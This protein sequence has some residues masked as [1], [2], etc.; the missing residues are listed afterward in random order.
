MA[1]LCA[2][3]MG[4][5]SLWLL[6]QILSKEQFG[7]YAFA[8]ATVSM[9]IPIGTVGLD[10]AALYRHSR[11]E[12]AAGRFAGGQ[13]VGWVVRR[14][15]ILGITISLTLA[16]GALALPDSSDPLGLGWWLAALGLLI[17]LAG[18]DRV[19]S[20]WQQARG[21]VRRALLVPRT[22]DPAKLFMLAIAWIAFPSQIGVV[23]A[24]LLGAATPV[25]VW[26]LLIPQGALRPPKKPSSE[27]LRYGEK[28]M[29]VNLAHGGV[30]RLDLLMIGLMTNGGLTA[31]YAVASQIAV[32]TTF[33]AQLVGPV[34]V[35]RMGR[36]F[37]RS[38]WEGLRVEY[39]QNRMLALFFALGV[40]AFF[41]LVGRPLLS[42]FGDYSGAFPILLLLGAAYVI[43]T[44]FGANT[45]YLIM[46]GRANWM[47]AS[48]IL[49]L[50]SIGGLNVLLIPRFGS[51]GAAAGTALG[52]AGVNA[53]IS[54]IIWRID[55]LSTVS[56]GALAVLAGACGL[57][58]LA[59]VGWLNPIPAGL[60][61][62]LLW[63]STTPAVYAI[64]VRLVAPTP[65]GTSDGE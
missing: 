39:E 12:P 34:F 3:P 15:V 60:G 32:L 64:S 59:A 48:T 13:Y 41:V 18:I 26:R 21:L 27:D 7:A 22:A 62:G 55:R 29:L 63:L 33:G 52:V 24:V 35:P 40:V 6:N 54:L 45:R 50:V 53:L 56:V 20:A 1:K 43:Q 28:L 2:L 31:E 38:D 5:A 57:L 42:V 4:F 61:L 37:E 8:M 30:S 51:L 36:Y 25:V 47:L 9:L 17:P 46:S 11:T 23:V 65:Q 58:V 10:G 14:V 16:L 19:L 49:T 44:G